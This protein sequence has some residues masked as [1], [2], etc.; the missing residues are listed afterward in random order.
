MTLPEELFSH[1]EEAARIEWGVS[2][3]L[4]APSKELS[5]VVS[6]SE[7]DGWLDCSLLRYPFFNVV[8]NGSAL[9]PEE[10]T[11]ARVVGGS[12]QDG[13]IDG[14]KVRRWLGRGA[15]LMFANLHEWHAPSQRLCRSLAERLSTK[16]TAAIFYTPAGH[17]GLKVHRD[18]S[19]V[20][21][22]QLAGTKLWSLHDTPKAP[23][24]WTPGFITSEDLVEPTRLE[25]RAG[26]ALY[27]PEGQAHAARSLGEPS[28]HL[29]LSLREPRLREVVSLAVAAC[30]SSIPEHAS[31]TGSAEQ[32]RRAAEDLLQRLSRALTRVEVPELVT[33]LE[34]RTARARGS[35]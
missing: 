11:S 18:D 4:F 14:A 24:D 3:L 16:V 26:Q 13:F 19:H 29:T 6:A 2:P 25:L 17:H 30:V 35:Y 27:V 31:L 8:S 1:A 9:P 28:M 21:V 32:R 33:S 34:R 22:V 10:L 12:A 5:S 7:L 23:E 20:I 15:T